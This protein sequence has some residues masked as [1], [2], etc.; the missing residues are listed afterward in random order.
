VLKKE[1]VTL[2]LGKW[3]EDELRGVRA[4]LGITDGE[5]ELKGVM[6]RSSLSALSLPRPEGSLL[7]P[8]Q[9]SGRRGTGILG[10]EAS[11][12]ALETPC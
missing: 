6:A 12:R 9:G 1:L 10:G 7:G 4:D 11:G 8:R 2:S 3:R 5:P